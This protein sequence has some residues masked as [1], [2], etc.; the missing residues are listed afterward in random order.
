MQHKFIKYKQVLSN[1]RLKVDGISKS[2][3]KSGRNEQMLSNFH[4]EN[5]CDRKQQ[6]AEVKNGAVYIKQVL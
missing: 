6:Q 3:A 5:S 4:T 2:K 1:Q